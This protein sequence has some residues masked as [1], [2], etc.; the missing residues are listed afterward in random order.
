MR[1]DRRPLWSWTAAFVALGILGLD[2]W[3]WDALPAVGWLGLPW[4]VWYFGV[5]QAVLAA[6]LWRFA[7]GTREDEAPVDSG[8]NP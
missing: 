5:L 7:S 8:P 6:A 4:R 1:V 3:W 2:Y